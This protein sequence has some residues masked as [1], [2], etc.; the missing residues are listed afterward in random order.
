MKINLKKQELEHIL[1]VLSIHPIDHYN[2]LLKIKNMVTNY[3]DH[4][5]A[6][7]NKEELIPGIDKKKWFYIPCN[8]YPCENELH[9]NFGKKIGDE[10]LK[11]P[12]LNIPF[13]K[14]CNAYHS[15]NLTCH[16]LKI[17]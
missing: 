17:T 2:L 13:C 5:W 7:C 6:N 4:E 12:R 8:D 11:I 3:C 10:F 9:F 1:Y 16:L 14:I 15:E